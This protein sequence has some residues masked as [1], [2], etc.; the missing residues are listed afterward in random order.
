MELKVPVD[1]EYRSRSGIRLGIAVLAA[2]GH[3]QAPL[4]RESCHHNC[5]AMHSH[6]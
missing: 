4:D 1:L 3:G 5:T 6:Y 2:P